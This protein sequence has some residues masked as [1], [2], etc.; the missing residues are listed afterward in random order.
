MLA[1]TATTLALADEYAFFSPSLSFYTNDCP[2]LTTIIQGSNDTTLFSGLMN[3]KRYSQDA[4]AQARRQSFNEMKPTTG[5]IG[6]MWN[7]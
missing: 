2:L 7:K 3:Q 5:F 6:K 4:A 1:A